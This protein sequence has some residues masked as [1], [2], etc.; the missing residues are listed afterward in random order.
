MRTG[1]ITNR[2]YIL[3]SL[4]KANL[5]SDHDSDGY[6]FAKVIVMCLRVLPS[7]HLSPPLVTLFSL[8]ITKVSLIFSFSFLFSFSLPFL[9]FSHLVLFPS[10]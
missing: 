7:L 5:W 6:A 3:W 10:N 8:R 1:S 9:V 4:L 2:V